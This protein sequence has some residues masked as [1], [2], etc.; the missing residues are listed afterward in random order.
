VTTR[1]LS[2]AR[3]SRRCRCGPWILDTATGGI[4]G[5]GSV[6][7]PWVSPRV[8]GLNARIAS[9]CPKQRSVLAS[10]WFHHDTLAGLI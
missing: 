7:L 10:T 6:A 3:R 2:P 8:P 4:I 1:D 5:S 9:Q